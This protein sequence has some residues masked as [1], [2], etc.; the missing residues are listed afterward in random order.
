MAGKTVFTTSVAI[1][2]GLPC[3]A[4]AQTTGPAS[5]P[6][7]PPAACAPLQIDTRRFDFDPCIAALRDQA[8]VLASERDELEDAGEVPSAAFEDREDRNKAALAAIT[9]LAAREA[10]IGEN[11]SQLADARERLRKIAGQDQVLKDYETKRI[12]DLEAEGKKLLDALPRVRQAA[13]RYAVRAFAAGPLQPTVASTTRAVDDV[14][15]GGC[16]DMI[17]RPRVT[18]QVA[19]CAAL[20]LRRSAI[21]IPGG[22]IKVPGSV[23][24]PPGASAVLSGGET[25]GSVTLTFAQQSKRRT[26]ITPH[27]DREGR[28]TVQRAAIFGSSIGGRAGN[29]TLYKRDTTVGTFEQIDNRAAITASLSANFFSGE[30]RAEWNGRAEKLR[31]AAFAACRADQQAKPPKYLSTCEGESLTGWVY[32]VGDNGTRLHETI[33]DQ[34]DKLYFGGN[35][36]VPRWGAGINV[37]LSHASHPYILPGDFDDLLAPFVDDAFKTVRQRKS[38]ELASVTAYLYARATDA[39]AP[40]GV[41][42]IPSYTIAE[43]LGYAPDY[44]QPLFC[45]P[46][47]TSQSFSTKECRRFNA[48][49]PDFA[50]VQTI[51]LEA[52]STFAVRGVPLIFAPKVSWNDQKRT[53]H[54]PW[55]ISLPALA[56]IDAA[57]T[58]AVGARLDWAFGQKDAQGIDQDDGVVVKLIYQKTFSLTGQ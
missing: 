52:R 56:F 1:L 54:Q 12:Q 29:G 49:A 32:A 6:E 8:N 42:F 2:V 26:R 27:T 41:S 36:A 44:E 4:S 9:D 39:D 28:E 18:L 51:A 43:T 25:G 34:A 23:L 57:R 30:S 11:D 58:S 20:A 45:P 38:S 5:V 19:D 13:Y 31:R 10:K 17:A 33:A 22:E 47:T 48:E 16:R 24:N 50:D 14:G 15:E 46:L 21:V 37:E 3:G 55:L 35:S 53:D 40:L 7:P